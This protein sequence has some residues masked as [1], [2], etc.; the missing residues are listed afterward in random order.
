MTDTEQ[1]TPTTATDPPVVGTND[2]CNA[3]PTTASQ[4]GAALAADLGADETGDTGGGITAGKVTG[5]DTA[6]TGDSIPGG[7]STSTQNG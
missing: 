3:V 6:T 7:V 4:G 5:N 1:T 2:E